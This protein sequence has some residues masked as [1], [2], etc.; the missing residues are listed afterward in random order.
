M[1]KLIPFV[2]ILFS[3]C[4]WIHPAVQKARSLEP[5]TE[6]QRK[7]D[8][9]EIVPQAAKILEC[10]APTIVEKVVEVVVPDERIQEIVKP[11]LISTTQDLLR[12]IG[13]QKKSVTE[14]TPPERETQ[15]ATSDGPQKALVYSIKVA[16]ILGVIAGLTIGLFL[17]VLLKRI[18][19]GEKDV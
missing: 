18:K 16:L 11:L 19:G 10:A 12:I 9:R 4:S 17:P 6:E 13:E 2:L 1:M 8:L 7:M 14:E 3:S 15:L 5:L